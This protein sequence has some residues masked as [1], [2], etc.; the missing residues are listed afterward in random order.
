MEGEPEITRDEELTNECFEIGRRLERL[1]GK[2][3]MLR[4]TDSTE[5]DAYEILLECLRR[6]NNHGVSFVNSHSE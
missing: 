6:I 4:L 2:L 5:R 3:E 1:F